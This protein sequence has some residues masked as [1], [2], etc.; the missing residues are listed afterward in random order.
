MLAGGE[1]AANLQSGAG[2]NENILGG[3]EVIRLIRN[4]F[5]YEAGAGIEFYFQYFKF[6]LE[7]KISEG[8]RNLLIPDN[9]V[10]TQSL[11]SL[12][13]QVFLVSITFEG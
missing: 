9:S 11:E 13:S 10:Y 2:V 1:Y 5:E 8:T 7:A 4:D 6:G 12:K 3:S